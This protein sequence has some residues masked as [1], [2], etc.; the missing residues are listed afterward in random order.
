MVPIKINL[1]Y[2]CVYKY[3]STEMGTIIVSWSTI[4]FQF[5]WH[6]MN[7]INLGTVFHRIT[8]I[9]IKVDTKGST[10]LEDFPC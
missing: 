7:R 1:T 3:V 4:V 6:F 10:S 9:T 5:D 2:I 8:G